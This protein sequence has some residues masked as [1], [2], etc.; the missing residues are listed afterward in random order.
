M[1]KD[2]CLVLGNHLLVFYHFYLYNNPHI[3]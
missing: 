1:L 2:D 3:N